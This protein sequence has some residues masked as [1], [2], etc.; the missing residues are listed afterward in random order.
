MY[1]KLR[2]ECGLP[3]GPKHDNTKIIRVCIVYYLSSHTVYPVV[4][5]TPYTFPPSSPLGKVEN[6]RFHINYIL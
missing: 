2:E 4:F 1:D 3:E 5:P 6:N